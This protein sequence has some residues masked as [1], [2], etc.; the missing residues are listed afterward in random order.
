LEASDMV[1]IMQ[2]RVVMLLIIQRIY[3]AN[4]V[5]DWTDAMVKRCKTFASLLRRFVAVG[6]AIQ[7]ATAVASR[8]RLI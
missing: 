7:L 5:H 3:A 4:G 6:D 8:A 2:Q 1:E